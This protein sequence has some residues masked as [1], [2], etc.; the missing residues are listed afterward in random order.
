[1]NRR[2]LVRNYGTLSA[3]LFAGAGAVIYHVIPN[4]ELRARQERDNIEYLP[5]TIVLPAG[6]GVKIGI[7]N[8]ID[9]GFETGGRYAMNDYLDG[10]TSPFARANDIYYITTVNLIYRIG[11][12]WPD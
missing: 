11:N 12:L 6:A 9:L 4:D 10:F 7:A 8:L 2:G 1:V 5:A 3:Y